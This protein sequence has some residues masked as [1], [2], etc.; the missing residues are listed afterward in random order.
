MINA[1]ALSLYADIIKTEEF[2]HVISKEATEFMKNRMRKMAKNKEVD[3]DD[4]T[5]LLYIKYIV[6]GLAEDISLKYVLL[7]LVMN[8]LDR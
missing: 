7:I 1:S 5:A 2:S 6:F 4:L 3:Y 8:L